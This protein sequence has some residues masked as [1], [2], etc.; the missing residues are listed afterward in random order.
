MSVDLTPAL[1]AD[2]K[3]K[4]GAVIEDHPLPWDYDVA[5]CTVHVI[6]DSGK[7]IYSN[8]DSARYRCAAR[9]TTA[10]N[11]AVVLALVAEVERLWADLGKEETQ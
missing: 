7:A 2:I 3:Q 11:P 6:D 4:A 1:L 10:A 8:P 5:Y 9:F